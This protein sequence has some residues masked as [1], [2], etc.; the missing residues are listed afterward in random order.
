MIG[1]LA[2]VLTLASAPGETR[3]SAVDAGRWMDA[4]LLPLQEEQ[5]AEEST[6]RRAR[7]AVQRGRF[8]LAAELF[9]TLRDRY[10]GSRY[11]PD[12]FYW[13]A[14]AL[15][16]AE[17][18]RE[19]LELL[20]RQGV[21]YPGARI[22]ADARDLELRI[23][24]ILGQRGDAHAAEQA[25]RQAE[26][27]LAVQQMEMQAR[28]SDVA[29]S[30]MAAEA[31][32]ARSQIAGEA[33]MRRAA[34]AME[35]A[36]ARAG[37]F[38]AQEGCEGDDVRQAA[39]QAL[40]QMESERAVPL[41]R[42]VLDR[43]DEC[44]V[45]LRKQAIFVLGQM[46]PDEVEELIIEVARSDPDPGVQE[47]AVFWLSQV[48]S[49]RAVEALSQILSET[50][51]PVL[52][53]NAIFAL[54]QHSGDR[55]AT[56]LRQ[57]ALDAS[58]SVRAREKAIFWLSQNPQ[59]ADAAFLMELYGQLDDEPGLKE[60]VFITLSQLDDPTAVDWVLERALDTSED[61]ALRKQA[62]F[63]AGQRSTISLGRL[64]GLYESLD[65]REMREQLIFLYAH[66]DEP[67]RVD[68]LI[69]VIET[70]EDAELRKRAIF[71]L[72]QTGDERAV[73]FLLS[74]VDPPR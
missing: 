33:S 46:D 45:P 38:E 36:A 12:S 3:A 31:A 56:V 10:P 71:W 60:H 74:L 39:L 21:T 15:Y 64:Q 16:R 62:L 58:K 14:F 65:D 67:E 7:E 73:E 63:W 40:M 69:E 41:L 28:E 22:N 20:E 50:D 29:E 55:A 18:L 25:I 1:M 17:H 34:M 54:S 9:A 6:Y 26:L 42:G 66:R 51:N 44:S 68:R 47:A 61:V 5:S 30:M 53:E 37:S 32:L 11:V 19:A 8:D 2:G 23:R 24:S 35:M 70:E 27:A 43:R 72:G 57:Y 59:H 52:Q 49:E 48:G 4:A 13:Q